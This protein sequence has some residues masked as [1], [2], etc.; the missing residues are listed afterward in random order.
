[1]KKKKLASAVKYSPGDPAPAL[2]V[3]GKGKNAEQ[4]IAIAQQAGIKTI[5]D[6]ALA[7][8]LDSWGSSPGVKPG[9]FIPPWCWE[10]TAKVLAFVMK[11]EKLNL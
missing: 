6:E 3:S 4:I 8:L 10:A 11:P 7:V 2:L 1:M 5:E 9:D